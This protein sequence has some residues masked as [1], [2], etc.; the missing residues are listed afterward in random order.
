MDLSLAQERLVALLKQVGKETGKKRWQA[1]V[2]RKTDLKPGH[3]SLL[4]SGDRKA[5][6]E[7]ITRVAKKLG[8]HH[9]FFFNASLKD[10]HYKDFVRIG[11]GP[12]SLPGL[13]ELLAQKPSPATVAEAAK[14]REFAAWDGAENL[15]ALSW[16]RVLLDLRRD[17]SD[18]ES[19]KMDEAARRYFVRSGLRDVS[20]DYNPSS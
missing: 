18:P 17:F 16:F 19:W 9:D 10:P 15:D 11:S 2:S 7:T 4:L 3:V 14:L 13:E 12:R 20:K 6:L 5:E 1:A 8:V